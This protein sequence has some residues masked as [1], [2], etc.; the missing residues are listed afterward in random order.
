MRGGGE[1]TILLD[2]RYAVSFHRQPSLRTSKQHHRTVSGE[3]TPRLLSVSL[4]N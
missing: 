3:D 1:A 4:L 2:F